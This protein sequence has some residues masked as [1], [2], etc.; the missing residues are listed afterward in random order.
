MQLLPDQSG[1]PTERTF[2]DVGGGCARLVED[3]TSLCVFHYVHAGTHADALCAVHG[4]TSE[5]LNLHDVHG[6]LANLLDASGLVV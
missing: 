4:K 6:M 2:R 5:R 3:S 1:A